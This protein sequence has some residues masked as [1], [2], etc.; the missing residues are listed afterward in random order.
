[1]TSKACKALGAAVDEQGQR[2]KAEQARIAE[3]VDDAMGML[4]LLRISCGLPP[5]DY[6][7]AKHGRKTAK[8]APGAVDAALEAKRETA[9]RLIN[10]MGYVRRTDT[11]CSKQGLVHITG[12]NFDEVFEDLADFDGTDKNA[13]TD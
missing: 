13:L 4:A 6:T 7:L 1:M 8:P 9:Q 11:Y 10:S 3:A 12:P 2:V 5:S